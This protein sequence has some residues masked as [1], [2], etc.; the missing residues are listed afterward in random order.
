[1]DQLGSNS[2]V[3]W[4]GFST[5]KKILED[6]LL[7]DSISKAGGRTSAVIDTGADLTVVSPAWVECNNVRMKPWEGPA[8][9]MAN[10]EKAEVYGTVEIDVSN[11]RGKAAGTALVMKLI[12][13]DL[14]LGNNFIRQFG[15]LEIVYSAEN[16]MVKLGDEL[17]LIR[18]VRIQTS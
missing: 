18:S 13:H 3:R 1:L 10:G 8:L 9:H 16:H 2:T 4:S 15:K 6:V 5:E 11:D 14:L 17:P 7:I 12:D